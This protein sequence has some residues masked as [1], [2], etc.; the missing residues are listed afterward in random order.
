M[1]NEVASL[2]PDKERE[3]LVVNA[4]VKSRLETWNGLKGNMF[5]FSSRVGIRLLSIIEK[6]RNTGAC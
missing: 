6:K 3:A 5:L 1:Y 2:H 4:G